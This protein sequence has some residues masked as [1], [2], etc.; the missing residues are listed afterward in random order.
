MIWYKGKSRFIWE[1]ALISNYQFF[2]SDKILS[3]NAEQA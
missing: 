1:A 2:N 3:S